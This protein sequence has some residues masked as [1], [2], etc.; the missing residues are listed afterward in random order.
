[1]QSFYDAYKL[2]CEEVERLDKFI[3]NTVSL[4][5]SIENCNQ[6][7]AAQQIE[8]NKAKVIA[9]LAPVVNQGISVLQFI[10]QSQSIYDNYNACIANI[11]SEEKALNINKTIASLRPIVSCAVTCKN[12][13]GFIN[14]AYETYVV[15]LSNINNAVKYIHLFDTYNKKLSAA[16]NHASA[17]SGYIQQVKPV[18]KDIEKIDA[19]KTAAAHSISA[20][21]KQLKKIKSVIEEA[22]A[23]R[24][25]FIIENHL[26]PCCGQTINETHTQSISEFMKD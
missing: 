22:K 25:V 19:Q 14:H 7:I 15:S 16:V 17:L 5:N 18:L 10:R 23:D 20:T 2:I 21:K 6:Q 12:D 9:E 8:C 3:T 1:M 26:C 13:I 11:E 4:Q 24:D